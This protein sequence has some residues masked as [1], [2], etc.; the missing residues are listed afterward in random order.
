M[1]GAELVDILY[2]YDSIVDVKINIQKY[3]QFQIDTVEFD[4]AS[5]T[6]YLVANQPAEPY[7]ET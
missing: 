2:R 7:N 4:S 3:E 6:L 1:T 5:S